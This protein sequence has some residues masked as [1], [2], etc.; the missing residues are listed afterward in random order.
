MGIV[1]RP[2]VSCKQHQLEH[3]K[4]PEDC[5]RRRPHERHSTRNNHNGSSSLTF[6]KSFLTEEDSPTHLSPPTSPYIT[7]NNSVP[8]T[9]SSIGNDLPTG[10]VSHTGNIPLPKQV[11]NN[12]VL[13]PMTVPSCTTPLESPTLS[14]FLRD[15]CAP[16]VQSSANNSFPSSFPQQAYYHD[17]SG[18]I[19]I[20]LYVVLSFADFCE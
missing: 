11:I 13:P 8:N 2:A 9:F 1:G 5:P 20:F 3:Q 15:Q 19:I 16:V 18:I 7:G 4:C 17:S 6:P 10:I 14:V 12:S